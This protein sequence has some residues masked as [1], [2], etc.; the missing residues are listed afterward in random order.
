MDL[1]YSGLTPMLLTQCVHCVHQKPGRQQQKELKTGTE[2]HTH[3][4]THTHTE[5]QKEL[6]YKNWYFSEVVV[7]LIICGDSP[8]GGR[9]SIWDRIYVSLPC[10]KGI[11]P[12]KKLSGGLLVW[13]SVWSKVQTC[14]WPSWCH[15]HSLSLASVKSRLVY[16]SGTGSPG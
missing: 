14:I 4:H 1:G 5:G 13:L 15:C 8:E 3:T 16:L 11:R 7:W 9:E 2:I 12:V 6:K 10:K